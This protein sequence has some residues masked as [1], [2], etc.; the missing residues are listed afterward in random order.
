MGRT[1]KFGWMSFSFD[2]SPFTMAQNQGEKRSGAGDNFNRRKENQWSLDFAAIPQELWFNVFSYGYGNHLILSG[3]S[4]SI[5]SLFREVST[6]S[7]SALECCNRYVQ[8]TPLTMTLSNLWIQLGFRRILHKIVWACKHQVLVG[9]LRICHRTLNLEKALIIF[10]IE[11]CTIVKLQHLEYSK[12]TALYHRHQFEIA[13]LATEL[14][15]PPN[16]LHAVYARNV[17]EANFQATLANAIAEKSSVRS[18]DFIVQEEN[19][20]MVML[21]KFSSTLEDFTITYNADMCGNREGDRERILC[22][23][24]AMPVLQKSTLRAR[25]CIGIFRIKS[26]SLFSHP[27]CCPPPR[28]SIA[29]SRPFHSQ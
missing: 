19:C 18:L 25:Q 23:V 8:E 13:Q 12:V 11:R 29:Y 17:P 5:A 26:T 14:G 1:F 27:V 9:D 6:V 21:Q 10:L 22:T 24:E 2:L 16:T 4:V 3:E 7:K 20:S 15:I 28:F